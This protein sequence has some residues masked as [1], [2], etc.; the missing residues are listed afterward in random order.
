MGAGMRNVWP[1]T[2]IVGW[3]GVQEQSQGK[4]NDDPSRGAPVL[5]C[6]P[7][8]TVVLLRRLK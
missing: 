7:V 4:N 5:F 2:A 6:A 8:M 1:A 3:L